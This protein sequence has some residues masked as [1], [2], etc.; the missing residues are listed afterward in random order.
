MS[1]IDSGSNTAGGISSLLGNNPGISGLV[2]AGLGA[3]AGA[4][5]G[6]LLGS[7]GLPYE[8]ELSGVVG[9][10]NSVAGQAQGNSGALFATGQGLIDPLTSGKLPQGAQ[11]QVQ[12]YVDK[13]NMAIKGR[14][15]SLG[16]TGSTMETDALNDVQKNASAQAFQIEQEMARTGLQATSQALQALG[17]TQQAY[18]ATAGIYENL[19]KSQ[20]SHDKDVMS[21]IGSFAG[22]FGKAA[23]GINFGSL[24]GGGG[25]GV[26]PE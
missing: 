20:M 23:V 10:L 26:R 18:G 16:Q 11:S 17:I 25:D 5:I 14:Y 9:N 6:A 2:G 1:F 19:M 13:Q 21:T 8:K 12:Q 4:G 22:A 15:A 24:F 3:G 7:D